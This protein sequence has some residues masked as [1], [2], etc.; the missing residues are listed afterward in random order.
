MFFIK[1]FVS[2]CSM[3]FAMLDSMQQIILL[4]RVMKRTLTVI[5]IIIAAASVYGQEQTGLVEIPKSAD[6]VAVPET[7]TVISEQE[8][9]EVD[10]QTAAEKTQTKQAE[11]QMTEQK[12]LK[13]MTLQLSQLV[14]I[15][16]TVRDEK[17]A[18]NVADEV[19]TLMEKLF[20]IDYA[21]IEGVDEEVVAAGLADLFNDLELQVSR[22][23]EEDFYG[24]ASLKETF[25]ADEDEN[26]LVEPD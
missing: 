24:N 15:L 1:L 5:A 20:A 7:E 25:G 8:S 14:S 19:E 6:A 16:S 22:L 9:T 18:A 26:S 13:E 21:Q 23:F 12:L 4:I 3:S 17:T 2:S 10:D 11:P